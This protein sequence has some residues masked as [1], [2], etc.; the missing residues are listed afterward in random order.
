MTKK[1]L[2]NLKKLMKEAEHL[3]NL[4]K[5]PPA[6]RE[7][8]SDTAKD[9]STG[10]PHNILISG[11]GD[12]KYPELQQR[13]HDKLKRIQEERKE[14]ED[15]LNN[16]PDSEIRDILRLQYINNLTH[17]Q[18]ADELDYKARETVTRK[19]QKFWKEIEKS[20]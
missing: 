16:V 6:L 10:Y 7:F 12:S 18:I 17:E 15:W 3:S 1:Q 9:Y 2:E 19:L 4:I 13:Y 11:Y 5:E 20:H 8:V 14:L